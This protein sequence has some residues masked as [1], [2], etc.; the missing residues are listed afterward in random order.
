VAPM[1]LLLII[2]LNFIIGKFGSPIR[3]SKTIRW[4]YY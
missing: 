1:R 2:L 4:V 3:I